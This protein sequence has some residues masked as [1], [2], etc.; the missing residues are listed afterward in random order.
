MN[1]WVEKRGHEYYYLQVLVNY[2]SRC[3]GSRCIARASLVCI[4]RRFRPD[5]RRKVEAQKDLSLD[6]EKSASEISG[7]SP[8]NGCNLLLTNTEQLG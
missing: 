6:A 5:D 7:P 3:L 8:F 2:P 1:W 4:L